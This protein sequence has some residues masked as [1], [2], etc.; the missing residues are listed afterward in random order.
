MH[1][2]KGTS[3]KAN[4]YKTS[5]S[6][7]RV[8]KYS[9]TTSATKE[10]TE[11]RT[12][13]N[14]PVSGSLASSEH[15]TEGDPHRMVPMVIDSTCHKAQCNKNTRDRKVT[16]AVCKSHPSASAAPGGW[17]VARA[18]TGRARRGSHWCTRS[19][20][21][22]HRTGGPPGHFYKLSDHVLR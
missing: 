22:A 21:G 11:Q 3:E 2:K 4:K 18:H 9:V 15:E 6:H 13:D 1:Q 16:A 7:T 20:P 12:Q 14:G 10:G 8:K 5:L 19:R 17:D